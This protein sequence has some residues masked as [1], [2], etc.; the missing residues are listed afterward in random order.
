M[1][2]MFDFFEAA[3]NKNVFLLRQVEEMNQMIIHDASQVKDLLSQSDESQ[4]SLVRL[5]KEYSHAIKQAE[6]LRTR[7]NSARESVKNLRKQLSDVKDKVTKKGKKMSAEDEELLDELNK[8]VPQLIRENKEHANELSMLQGQYNKEKFEYDKVADLNKRYKEEYDQGIASVEKYDETIVEMAENTKQT[9]ADM[10]KCNKESDELRE[11]IENRPDNSKQIEKLKLLEQELSD[12]HFQIESLHRQHDK[13]L[14]K[15]SQ[16]KKD[17]RRVQKD[18]AS[19]EEH[20]ADVKIDHQ[21]REEQYKQYQETVKQL[22]QENKA[23]KPNYREAVV[24]YR[25]IKAQKEKLKANYTDLQK[26][27]Y[28]V[29]VKFTKSENEKNARLRLITAAKVDLTKQELK[30]KDEETK[31][32]EV[33]GQRQSLIYDQVVAKQKSCDMKKQISIIGTETDQHQNARKQAMINYL[34]IADV[35]SVNR[36]KNDEL[37]EELRKIRKN[38]E[39]EIKKIEKIREERSAIKKQIENAKNEYKQWSHKY[40]DLIG[41]IQEMTDRIGELTKM[42][43]HDR[44]FAREMRVAADSLTEMRENTLNGMKVTEKVINNLTGEENTLKRLIEQTSTDQAKNLKELEELRNSK[45]E[46][47]SQ[48]A[49]KL[50]E[51]EAKEHDIK[52]EEIFLERRAKDFDNVM[53]QIEQLNQE[54]EKEQKITEE[55]E[56]KVEYCN[57]LKISYTALYENMVVTKG[58]K[59]LLYQESAYPVGYHR[60]LEIDSYDHERFMNIKLIGHLK[61]KLHK[62]HDKHKKLLEERDKLKKETQ[63]IK[64]KDNGMPKEEAEKYIAALKEDLHEKTKLIKAIKQRIDSGDTDIEQTMKD[65]KRVRQCISQRKGVTFELKTTMVETARSARTQRSEEGEEPAYYITEPPLVATALGGGFRPHPPKSPRNPVPRL[66]L[67]EAQQTNY[68]Q[69]P[70]S[71]RYQRPNLGSLRKK[72]TRPVQTP[73]YEK[74]NKTRVSVM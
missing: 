15:T 7:E 31:T 57:F 71:Q 1:N 47:Q 40:D 13:I 5:R 50:R 3:Y 37:T 68:L 46:L 19:K 52:T 22:E 42:A 17:L 45:F 34:Q 63:S 29:S 41:E 35:A 4:N 61:D 48:I 21:K 60:W 18:N 12:L 11:I 53:D 26:K 44:F 10:A 32:L 62:L 64:I 2:Q 74:P 30:K 16:R 66:R 24:K 55:L 25:E 69:P 27:Y 33:V 65:M 73:R 51:I 39:A 54:L 14:V 8:E 36:Q 23:E 58:Q 28:D 20:L 6:E 67:E 38:T 59:K 70:S 56:K 9:R 72:L 43:E 49:E